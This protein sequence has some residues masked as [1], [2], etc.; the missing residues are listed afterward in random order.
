MNLPDLIGQRFTR[1]VVRRALGS[2]KGQRWWLAVCDCGQ[3]KRLST[4]NLKSGGF[5]SC[6]CLRRE[7]IKTL[8][9]QINEREAGSKRTD[10]MGAEL[11]DP[12]AVPGLNAAQHAITG[13]TRILTMH[14]K[15][16][17]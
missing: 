1:L 9:K 7:T 14:H 15:Y 13:E 12:L 4:S 16:T 10:E 11:S 2:K 8:Y 6:G 17:K 5:K 3:E